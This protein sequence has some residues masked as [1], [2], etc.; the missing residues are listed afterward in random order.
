MGMFFKILKGSGAFSW[1]LRICFMCAIFALA[2]VEMRDTLDGTKKFKGVFWTIFAWHVAMAVFYPC[3]RAKASDEWEESWATAAVED[4][5]TIFNCTMMLFM[6]VIYVRGD[7]HNVFSSYYIASIMSLATVYIATNMAFGWA[8][9]F[10]DKWHPKPM[11]ASKEAEEAKAE[12][13]PAA[14]A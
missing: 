3:G 9:Y 5:L 8:I 14:T 13:L 6:M 11:E 7:D 2:E 1:L 4:C 10:M 12:P